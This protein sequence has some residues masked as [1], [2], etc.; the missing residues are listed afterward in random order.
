MSISL[1]GKSKHMSNSRKRKL[2]TAIAPSED[3][4]NEFI[5]SQKTTTKSKQFNNSGADFVSYSYFYSVSCCI[6]FVY[7][8]FTKFF[9]PV[10]HSIY[11]PNIA[12]F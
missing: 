8:F 7:N 3:L 5:K 4:I 11:R 12:T 2:G 10:F 9:M 1:D 6:L